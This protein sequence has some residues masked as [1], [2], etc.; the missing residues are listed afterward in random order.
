M[1]RPL[2]LQVS[3]KYST[4][5]YAHIVVSLE[6]K[7]ISSYMQSNCFPNFIQSGILYL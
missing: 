7:Q 5:R 2:G 6:F 4:F 3:A 1:E